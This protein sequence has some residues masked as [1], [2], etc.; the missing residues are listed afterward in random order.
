[1]PKTLLLLASGLLAL[2]LVV[3]CESPP[4]PDAALT[5]AGPRDRVA[6]TV[7]ETSPED[8]ASNVPRDTELNFRFSEPMAL[9]VGTVSVAPGG[10]R[11]R[12]NESGRWNDAGNTL[13][14]ELPLPLPSGEVTVTLGSDFTDRSGNS[15]LETRITFTT[16]DDVAP[17]VSSSTPAEGAIDVGARL[18]AITLTFDEPM[19][20]SD[21][22]ID[23]VGGAAT[24]SDA[25]WSSDGTTASFTVADLE[26][27][28][29]YQAL[30][31]GFRDASGNPLDEVPYL[32]DGILDFSTGTDVDAPR[33]ERGEPAEGQLDVNPSETPAVLITFDEPMD[34]TITTVRLSDGTSDDPLAGTWIGPLLLRVDVDGRLSFGNA[35]AIDLRGLSDR[36]G[37]LIDESTYLGDGRLDFTVGNDDFAPFVRSSAPAEGE[38]DVAYAGLEGVELSFSE[39]MDTS[40]AT[41]PVRVAADAP[42][43][44]PI[45]FSSPTEATVDLTGILRPGSEHRI[46]VRG[47]QDSGGNPINAGHRY[48]GDGRLDFTTGAPVGEGCLDPLTA[49]EATM[50]GAVLRW[51][52]SSLGASV[53]DG[54]TAVC[55]SNGS[56][57]N[58]TDTLVRFDK[59]SGT[60]AEGGDLLR[61]VLESPSGTTSSN[62][63]DIAVA[64]GLACAASRVPVVC[65]SNAG[66]H[67]LTLDLA[68]GPVWIWVSRTTL[69]T[70]GV[71]ATL[72]VT[73][74]TPPNRDG[75]DCSSPFTTASSG[76][77][78]PVGGST[79]HRFSIPVSSTRGADMM[80]PASYAVPNA[81]S[82]DTSAGQGIDAVVEFNKPDD[83]SVLRIRA[84]RG[85]TSGDSLNFGV[86]DACDALAPSTRELACRTAVTSTGTGDLVVD[87]PAGP[88]YLWVSDTL[89]TV[90]RV[91][92]TSEWITSPAA[93]IE[94]DVIPDVTSGEICSRAFALS[95]GANAVTGTSDQ[96]FERPSCFGA[97]SNVEW[98]RITTTDPVTFVAADAAGGLAMMLPDSRQELTCVA[99]GAARSATRLLPV[100][101]DLCVAVEMGRS[102]GNITVTGQAYDGLG[103]TPPVELGIL[104]PFNATASAEETVTSDY[105]LVA[106]SDSLVMRHTF[107]AVFDVSRAGMERPVRRGTEDGITSSVLGRTAVTVGDAVFSFSSTTTA[108]TT[109]VHRLWDGSSLFWAPTPWDP[110]TTYVTQAIA[111][112]A[113]DGAGGMWFV[114]DGSSA[115]TFYSLSASA[116]SA[117]TIRGVTSLVTLIRGM[118]MDDQF[119]YLQG[120]VGGL[121]GIYRLPRSNLAATP[122]TLVISTDFPTSTTQA[123]AMAVDSLVAPTNLYVRDNNGDVQVIISPA[124]ASPFYL[125]PVIDLGTSSDFAMTLA[126]DTGALYLFE[127]ETV[128]TGNWVRYDP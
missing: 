15:L 78:A 127:T 27:E 41:V 103:S 82:C 19:R 13:T 45:L 9:D 93:E 43:D 39:A 54:G 111:G 4:T 90:S 47:L 120:V 63:F 115:A 53:R 92:S 105:W 46:D 40:A 83:T 34:T 8:G 65:R 67:E 110:G 84:A 94:I 68:A 7:E 10:V 98:Y 6:P 5:D 44:A 104:R 30:L 119:V 97:S 48:L 74:I 12:A 14:V 66:F 28:R 86:Y 56:T 77:T 114:T 70:S 33:V 59:L 124:S 64:D 1:M 128:S 51:T 61:V 16:A 108:A 57:N 122:T 106:T 95:A 85:G 102:I 125:G 3:A 20:T 81:F 121:R 21:G 58:G 80:G 25:V 73:E 52:L 38:L 101:T 23:L 69:S 55:D 2:S 89:T 17:S 62:T 113:A 118:A 79:T 75:E 100:G 107:S 29:D 18:D 91:S 32:E 116:P 60:V 31:R 49:A 71:T 35:Y 22:T 26:Y 88:L 126:H 42:I 24:L 87:L 72:E 76:Y 117:S 112:A 99:N 37:N 96:A 109:R 36:A 11:L 50:E 123:T